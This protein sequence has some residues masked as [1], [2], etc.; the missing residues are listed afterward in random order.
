MTYPYRP[1][2]VKSIS[3]RSLEHEHPLVRRA[4]CAL[5]LRSPKPH[6]RKRLSQ[7]I[8]RPDHSLS[9]LALY[10]WRFLQDDQVSMEELSRIKAGSGSDWVFLR[11]LPQLYAIA[12]TDSTNVAKE[13]SDYLM[14]HSASHS[15]KVNW[16]LKCLADA[17]A[18]ATHPASAG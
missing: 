8:H 1:Q 12:A 14:A 5:S 7:L 11:T 13:L 2:Y 18:W 4:A 16:H 9:H 17:T 3:E 15:A 6:V 10:F